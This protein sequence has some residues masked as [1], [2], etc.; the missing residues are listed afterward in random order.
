MCNVSILETL[1]NVMQD[2]FT[3]CIRLY[4]VKGI[5]VAFGIC[6]LYSMVFAII[7]YM[8]RELVYSLIR[9]YK[10]ELLRSIVKMYLKLYQV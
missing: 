2:L 9:M 3:T 8:V 5:F 1:M 4:G 6:C 7:F 10:R